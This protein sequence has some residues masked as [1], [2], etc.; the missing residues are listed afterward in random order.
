MTKGSDRLKTELMAKGPT[1]REMKKGPNII[2]TGR[3]MGFGKNI[4]I[5][6]RPKIGFWPKIRFGQKCKKG[7]KN[8]KL[9]THPLFLLT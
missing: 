3:K 1:R 6:A 4:K 2:R 8:T 7:W 5:G 9:L